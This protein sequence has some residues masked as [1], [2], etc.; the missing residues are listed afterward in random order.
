[1]IALVLSE[2]AEAVGDAVRRAVCDAGFEQPMISR[3]RAA[4]GAGLCG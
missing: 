3:T 2:R 4:A 1:V